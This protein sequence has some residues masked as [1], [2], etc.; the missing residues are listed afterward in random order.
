MLRRDGHLMEVM[1]GI[2]HEYITVVDPARHEL[3]LMQEIA[4]KPWLKTPE[5]V[6]I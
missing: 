1:V 4:E 2:S 6:F 5:W 3:L